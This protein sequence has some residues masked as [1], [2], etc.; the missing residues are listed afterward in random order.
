MSEETTE[1]Y[2]RRKLRSQGLRLEKTPP[3][4][5]T[6]KHYPPGYQIVENGIVV[7]GCC[8]REYELSLAEVLEF[9]RDSA[10]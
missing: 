7:A 2:M 10:E 9:S 3:R 8:Q 1:S 5:W 6:R 4:H